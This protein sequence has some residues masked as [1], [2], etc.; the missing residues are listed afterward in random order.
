MF[1]LRLAA[2]AALALTFVFTSSVQAQ[3]ATQP[4]RSGSTVQATADEIILH[5]KLHLAL[6]D[7]FTVR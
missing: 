1:R 5:R 4:S 7:L 3:R 2:F 6:W